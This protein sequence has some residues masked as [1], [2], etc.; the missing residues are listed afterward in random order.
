MKKLLILFI[1]INFFLSLVQPG[2]AYVLMPEYLCELGLHFYHQGRTV[3]ALHEFNK[4]LIIS[5]GYEPALR[6]INMIQEIMAA[7]EPILEPTILKPA[8]KTREQAIQGFLDRMEMGIPPVMAIPELGEEVALPEVL[9]LD[10]N[11]NRLKFPLEIEQGRSIIIQGDNIKRYL[12]TQPDVLVIEKISQ[13]QILVTGKDIGYSYLHVWDD[14]GRW[15]LEF[16]TVPPKPKGP[17]L[18]EQLRR[19]AE[20]AAN[21]KLRYT[22]DWHCYE[23]GRR[24]NL[25]KRQ[26]YGYNHLLGLQ[27]P[28]PYGNIDAAIQV[29]S[30]RTS[31]DLTYATLGLTEGHLGPFEDFSLRILD[32]SP[33]VYNLA[34]L[35]TTLRGVKLESP[36]FNKK[37]SYITF[38]GREGGGRYGGLSPGLSNNK[39]SYLAGVDLDY[40]AGENITY[41]ASILHGWGDERRDSPH[42]NPWGYDLYTDWN[43]DK[44]DLR[45]EL[46][47]DTRNLSHLLTAEYRI[48]KFSLF[49]ELRNSDRNF[50]T[51]NGWG[52]RIGEIGVLLNAD[53]LPTDKLRLSGHLDVYRDRM[54]PSEDKLHRWNTN[55]DTRL[56][57][58]L[59][60]NTSLRLDYSLQNELGRISEFRSHNQGIGFYKTFDWLRRLNTYLTYRHQE[61]KHFTNPKLNYINNKISLGLRF[62]LIGEL[63]YYLNKEL[64]WLDQRYTAQTARPQALETGLDYYSQIFNTPFW[65]NM[66]FLYRD[67]ED[68]AS[69]LSFLSGEDYIEGYLELAYRPNPDT[70]LYGSMRVRNVWADNP[71]VDK[72]IEADFYTGL[73]YQWDTGFR[74]EAIGVVDGYVFKDLNSD[75][76]RQDQEL[77]VAGI[78]IWMGKKNYQVTDSSGY[79]K[80]PK[81][82]AKEAYITLDTNTIPAGYVPTVPVTQQARIVQG[83]QTTLYFGLISRSEIYG[84][85]FNDVDGDGQVDAGEKGIK[86]VILTLEDGAQATTDDSGRYFFRG[87]PTGEHIITLEMGSLPF[88]YLPTVPI[89][90][91]INLNEGVSYIYNIPLRQVKQ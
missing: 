10:E 86:G 63:Y 90:K 25:L 29:R 66:R 69:D 57:Y 33:N 64:N 28:T 17:T 11:I 34:I 70:E 49:T 68:T 38:V 22:F 42:L 53:Y 77:P 82:K 83:G 60:P 35:Q 20:K 74:W 21:F 50:V 89:Y 4:A 23:Q 15:T 55:F 8:I 75:G 14:R 27:G 87:A 16:L 2:Y 51:M 47:H 84:F 26:S 54:F 46:A 71:N 12:A 52:W 5:P 41:G 73:R 76:L 31:T 56:Y 1:T 88:E 37:I 39:D 59:D 32:F 58:T 91:K 9:L 61:N 81:I 85:I 19:E 45:Y 13:D 30:L 40:F 65:V 62:S 24:F 72:R 7:P 3:E 18:E 44:W 36:A 80:F 78:K 48:P 67:E 79:F 6:Y 43:L